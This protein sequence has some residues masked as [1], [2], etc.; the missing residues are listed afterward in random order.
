MVFGGSGAA[1]TPGQV[2]NI[3]N[4]FNLNGGVVYAVGGN[5]H[6]TGP[7]SVTGATNT[8]L[9]ANYA[10]NDLYLDGAITGTGGL[11]VVTAGN[12]GAIFLTASNNFSGGVL[13]DGGFLFLGSTNS[14]G[15]GGLV[16]VDSGNAGFG[17]TNAID[18][19]F[20]NYLNGLLPAT[21]ASLN[22]ML[23]VNST[24]SMDWSALASLTNV[25][26]APAPGRIATYSG[27]LNPA[28]GT[29]RGEENDATLGL[30]WYLNP[31]TRVTWNYVCAVPDRLNNTANADNIFMMRIYFDF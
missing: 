26:L 2:Y 12:G 11:R 21:G 9:N 5:Q 15:S 23:L 6:L 19:N 25:Y 3:T 17:P 10:F 8:T 7:I 18:Q 31:N 29:S 1:I 28:N 30:N 20:A 16:I 13:L 24:N 4:A 27:A 22:V 14:F